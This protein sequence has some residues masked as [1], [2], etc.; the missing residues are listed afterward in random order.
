MWWQF[1]VGM[2]YLAVVA[3]FLSGA[4]GYHFL[5]M[6]PAVV[7]G[8]VFCSSLALLWLTLWALRKDSRLGQFGLGSLLFLTLFVALYAGLVRWL[9][10]A[11]GRARAQTGGDGDLFVQIAV[12]CLLPLLIAIPFVLRMTESLLWLA[13]WILRRRPIRKLLGRRRRRDC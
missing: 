11:I 6:L 1:L 7:G 3:A 13:V 10:V 8:T 9:V 5:L 2:L 12:V 4:T